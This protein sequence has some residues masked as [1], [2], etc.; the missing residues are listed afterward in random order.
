M[1]KY[2]PFILVFFA[3]VTATAALAAS[4]SR[5][6]IYF[7]P[8]TT[9]P[10]YDSS[11]TMEVLK[12]SV[13]KNPDNGILIEGHSDAREVRPGDTN[14]EKFSN[15][16]AKMRADY[17]SKWLSSSIGRPLK[18][19][20]RTYGATLPATSS[21]SPRGRSANRRV[22]VNLVA[23]LFTPSRDSGGTPQVNAPEME[24]VFSP[25]FENTVI[26]HDFKIRNT[27]K[28]PLEIRDVKPG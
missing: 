21:D 10:K 24:F 22:E 8:L 2:L 3:I 1:K 26:S 7:D 11:R 27:G 12:S 9:T 17:V 25:V 18:C 13:V 5:Y 15:D 4:D 16:L 6:I 23:G 14:P 20:V 19:E 28:A